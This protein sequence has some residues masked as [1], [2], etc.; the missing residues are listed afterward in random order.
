M[1]TVSQSPVAAGAWVL[2]R[3]YKETYSRFDGNRCGFTPS[4]SRFGLEAVSARGAR[5]VMLTSARLMR[6]HGPREREFYRMTPRGYLRD[7]LENYT[8]FIGAPKLDAFHE[9]DDPA[10][11]WFLHVRATRRL[12]RTEQP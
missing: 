3:T 5:G 6:N 12:S 2:F 7:P 8:F 9:H 11:A 1:S 4:C 10:H